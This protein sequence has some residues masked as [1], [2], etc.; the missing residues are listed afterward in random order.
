MSSVMI[1]SRSPDLYLALVKA[2]TMKKL[3]SSLRE[4]LLDHPQH[5]PRILKQE[6]H[7]IVYCNY[8]QWHAAKINKVIDK[9]L[10][11]IDVEKSTYHRDLR[12]DDL[13]YFGRSFTFHQIIDNYSPREEMESN[14]YQRFNAEPDALIEKLNQR[15]LNNNILRMIQAGYII[16]FDENGKQC[17]EMKLPWRSCYPL[18]IALL[19]RFTKTA[20]ND[21]SLMPDVIGYYRKVQREMEHL[22]A[23]NGGCDSINH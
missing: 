13:E 3:K 14:Q 21:N 15:S 23:A 20:G 19:D 22:V 5:M 7:I 2:F 17:G 9:H 18:E 11:C 4:S 10:H 1:Q 12:I 8:H 16:R 6:T